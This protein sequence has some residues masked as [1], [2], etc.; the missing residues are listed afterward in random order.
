M[1][2]LAPEQVALARHHSYVLLSQLFLT[3]VTENN[4]SQVQA[5]F[6]LGKHL[7]EPIDLDA[8]AAAHYQLFGF[9]VFPF[10]SIFLDSNGLLGGVI[11]ESVARDMQTF[12]F[13]TDVSS[14]A[15]DHIGREVAALAHLCFALAE[16]IENSE[17]ETAVSLQKQQITFLRAHLLRWLG[18]F[19]LAV[20]MQG[21]PFYT[22]VAEWTLA[23]VGHHYETLM[24][25]NPAE[26]PAQDLGQAPSLL[27]NKKTGLKDIA[28]YL[29]T[30]IYSG[31]Y[32]S[33]DDIGKVARQL[34]LPRGFGDRQQLLTNLMRTAVQYDQFSQLLDVLDTAVMQWQTNYKSLAAEMTQLTPFIQ[35]WQV[36]CHET[37]QQ[38]AK[39][40]DQ[41]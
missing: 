1:D 20:K 36:K 2:G 18:P 17:T 12:S 3:G 16:A 27:D 19:V 34:D 33:R 26:M 40:R 41:I 24:K 21:D 8:L 39:I 14:H 23:L 9:N 7:P 28:N 5:V 10:E 38:I 6:D 13:A 35:S 11:T 15:P 32:L 4:L 29:T 37:S 25:S 22:A 30:P 31:F